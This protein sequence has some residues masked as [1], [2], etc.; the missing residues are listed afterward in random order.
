MLPQLVERLHATLRPTGYDYEF[1]FVNDCSNDRSLEILT[2][3]GETD[4]AIHVVTM[5][6]RFGISPC[7]LAGMGYATGDAIITMDCDLQDPP[8]I[9]PDFIAKWEEGADVVYGTRSVR[10]GES[11]FKM[12]VTKWAYR[13]LRNFSSID[14]PVDTGMYRLMTRRVVDTLLA[15]PEKDPF[16]RGL[17]SWVGYEQAQVFYRREPRP[18]G[19]THFPLLSKAPAKEFIIGMLSFSQL[20]LLFIIAIGFLT[21]GGAVIALVAFIG[22]RATASDIPFIYA[23]LAFLAFLSAAQL[24]ASAVLWLYLARIYNQVRSRPEY[25]VASTVGF[26]KDAPIGPN[27]ATRDLAAKR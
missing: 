13:I 21:I 2:E 12:F 16:L 23:G 9:M 19:E 27:A 17:V 6:S 11:A 26:D 18:A 8:E 24:L 25:I 22:A 1:V 14:L 5:S 20:P 15:I 7:F 3:L 4:P 10:E